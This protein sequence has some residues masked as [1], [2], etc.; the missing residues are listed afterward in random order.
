MLRAI[1]LLGMGGT[2]LMISPGL[3]G[4]LSMGVYSVTDQ[5]ALYAPWS[6]IAGVVVLLVILF[7]SMYRGA[8]PH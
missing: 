8:Q 3:R 4:S 6:Y 2:F 1:S 7:V 5:M